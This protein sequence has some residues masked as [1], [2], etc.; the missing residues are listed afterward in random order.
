MSSLD[1]DACIEAISQAADT[2]AAVA[3]WQQGFQQLR[4]TPLSKNMVLPEALSRLTD[5]VITCIASQ[6]QPASFFA[7][8]DYGLQLPLPYESL[9]LLVLAPATHHDELDKSLT[10]LFKNTSL[11]FELSDI[12]P[13]NQHALQEVLT[14]KRLLSARF[15]AG[16]ADI[17]AAFYQMQRQ[18][19][20]SRADFVEATSLQAQAVLFST[21]PNLSH[22]YG[23]LTFLRQGALLRRFATLAGHAPSPYEAQLH[24]HHQYL[25]SICW[26][27]QCHH[28]AAQ[29][30]VDHPTGSLLAA[31]LHQAPR[32][33]LSTLLEHLY[34]ITLDS[35][36]LLLLEQQY[37]REQCWPQNTDFSL[38][39]RR[40]V[41]RQGHVDIIHGDIFKRWPFAIIEMLALPTEEPNIQGFTHQSLALA[42][43]HRGTLKPPTAEQNYWFLRLIQRS[44]NLFQSLLLLHQLGGLEQHIPEFA[45]HK[46]KLAHGQGLKHPMDVEA[47]FMVQQLQRLRQPDA[48]RHAPLAAAISY[49]IPQPGLL[50]I[51]GLFH[52]LHR[53]RSH[54]LQA[55]ATF[56]QQH[57]LPS[58][59]SELVLWLL[60][61]QDTM[62]TTAAQQDVSQ[63][64]NIY[65]FAQS[66]K[67]LR[68]LDYLYLFSCAKLAAHKD[69]NHW[70]Q[71]RL[72]A[73]Y[74]ASKKA[75]R[76]GLNNPVANT[77]WAND[78]RKQAAKLLTEQAISGLAIQR[79]W[80]QIGDEYFLRETPADIAWHTHAI[81]RHQHQG[82]LVL[83]RDSL[84]ALQGGTQVF[85]YTKDSDYLFATTVK[86]LED[87]GLSVVAANIITSAHGFS[88][89][90]YTVV[91]AQQHPITDTQTLEHIQHTLVTVLSAPDRFKANLPTLTQMEAS[92]NTQ[93]QIA[94]SADGFYTVVALQTQDQPGL[95]TR[96]AQVFAEFEYNLH[97]ARIA[98]YGARVEDTFHISDNRGLP[99]S[100]AQQ[101][102]ALQ[103]ALINA[104]G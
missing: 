78:T 83:L 31:H 6:H 55:A 48:Q 5:A 80:A 89:D 95:L 61:H 34:R 49:H 4:Q 45:A 18:A 77:D 12:V 65:A 10:Q 75:L 38:I 72:D 103:R 2:Y 60:E 57:H 74:Q 62:L 33:T 70:Q 26:F 90:T 11:V 47:L 17:A 42:W 56:C 21:A 96:V 79:L 100:E 30:I 1:I 63:P 102:F 88:L 73:L 28:R 92:H 32:F 81:L 36:R 98:T 20:W 41:L 94:S 40:F 104:L 14:Y 44:H 58:W 93:V 85:I 87:L 39:N 15:I 91:D 99:L 24:G 52:H 68:H 53:Q 101:G 82:P 22:C 25:S 7:L 19:P 3:A 35:A 37:L 50:Y 13:L 8:E 67:N 54:C 27:L 43:T 64:Q 86:T 9:S 71:Q 16:N 46:G 29:Y 69:K 84:D 97:H 66:V 51:V 76:R 59:E 23:G